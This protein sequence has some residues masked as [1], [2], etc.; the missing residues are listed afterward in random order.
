MSDNANTPTFRGTPDQL[1]NALTEMLCREKRHT[2]RAILG[3]AIAALPADDRVAKLVDALRF[4]VDL[5]EGDS[6]GS[7]WKRGQADF[8]RMA[9]AAL[10]EWEAGSE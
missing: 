6:F 8:K 5:I 9:R 10:A 2:E 1:R 3:A 4:G 7:E